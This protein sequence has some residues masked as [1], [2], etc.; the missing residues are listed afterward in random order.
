M[1]ILLNLRH[2]LGLGFKE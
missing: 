1:A 2:W